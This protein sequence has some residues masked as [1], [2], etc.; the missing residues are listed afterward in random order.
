[1]V[2][3]SFSLHFRIVSDVLSKIEIS[4]IRAVLLV[5]CMVLMAAVDNGSMFMFRAGH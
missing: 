1:M 2:V 4:S 3:G 5:M